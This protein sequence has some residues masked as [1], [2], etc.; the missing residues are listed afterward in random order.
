MGHFSWDL[1]EIVPVTSIAVSQEAEFT[2]SLSC[3]DEPADLD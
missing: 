1:L 3:K 2:K